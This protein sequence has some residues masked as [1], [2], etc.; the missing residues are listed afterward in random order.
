MTSIL[1][2]EEKPALKA[3]HSLFVS[4]NRLPPHA[5]PSVRSP[6]VEDG[7]EDEFYINI[8]TLIDGEGRRI[9]MVSLN[10]N[11]KDL[12]GVHAMQN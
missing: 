6:I 1:S 2:R 11:N 5:F 9:W 4:N 7:E 12:K 8:S 10:M 3:H